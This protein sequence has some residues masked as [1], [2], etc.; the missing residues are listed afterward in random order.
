MHR[1]SAWAMVCR[2]K[3]YSRNVG[4]CHQI[5]VS[6]G[7]LNSKVIYYYYLTQ[8]DID[9]SKRF[10]SEQEHQNRFLRS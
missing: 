3:D 10:F 7:T 1:S 9:Y 6:F 8:F 2:S 5:Q 4:R